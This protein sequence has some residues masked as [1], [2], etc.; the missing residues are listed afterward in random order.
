[1]NNTTWG[2]LVFAAYH[3]L[4]FFSWQSERTKL[5]N[6]IMSRSYHEYQFAEN[7]DKTLRPDDE[8][9]REGIKAEDALAEDLSPIQGFGMN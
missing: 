8:A 1:M 2:F 4:C 5:I 6:K 3:L 7:V 9:L